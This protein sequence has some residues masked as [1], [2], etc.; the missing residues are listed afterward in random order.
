MTGHVGRGETEAASGG[1][2]GAPGQ[3]SAV[4]VRPKVAGRKR[5]VGMRALAAD[6]VR[7]KASCPNS[8]AAK[9]G[10]SSRRW[11]PGVSGVGSSAPGGRDEDGMRPAAEPRAV[12]WGTRHIPPPVSLEGEQLRSQRA[13]LTEA[14]RADRRVNMCPAPGVSR[15]RHSF[16]VRLLRTVPERAARWRGDVPESPRR[17]PVPDAPQ[18]PESPPPASSRATAAGDSGPLITDA[19]QAGAGGSKEGLST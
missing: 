18:P 17:P 9:N 13:Q 15:L 5:L 8:S 3:G 14:P 16:Q 6:D 19:A 10:R 7:G 12:P 1:P 11:S 2:P 4:G